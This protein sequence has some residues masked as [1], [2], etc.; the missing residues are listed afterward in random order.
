MRKLTCLKTK[1]VDL[2]LKVI[3]FQ[4]TSKIAGIS[5]GTCS[6]CESTLQITEYRLLE[7]HYKQYL[8]FTKTLI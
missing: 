1:A 8:Y 2:E 5:R 4:Q 3:F 7:Q 6:F